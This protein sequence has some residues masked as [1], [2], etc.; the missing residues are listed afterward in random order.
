M[1]T[2]FSFFPILFLF[3]LNTGIS[4]EKVKEH[5]SEPKIV[6]NCG[7]DAIDVHVFP[8]QGFQGENPLEKC[9]LID[10]DIFINQ[11]CGLYE[12]VLVP[13]LDNDSACSWY[14]LQS[15]QNNLTFPACNGGGIIKI[16]ARDTWEVCKEINLSDYANKCDK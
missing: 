10:V 8:I 13:E 6:T 1:K 2:L 12:F 11:N 9:C 16:M 15:G 14:W 3:M 5:K 4:P 7:C